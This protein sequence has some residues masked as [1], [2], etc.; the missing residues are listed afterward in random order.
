MIILL[1]YDEDEDNSWKVNT[2]NENNSF[3][4]CSGNSSILF[5]YSVN[6]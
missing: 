2:L 5:C 4:K 1:E 3:A 6:G